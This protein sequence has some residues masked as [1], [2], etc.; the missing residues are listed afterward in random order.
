MDDDEFDR[1]DEAVEAGRETVRGDRWSK[2]LSRSDLGANVFACRL[3]WLGDFLNHQGFA[4]QAQWTVMGPFHESLAFADG[5][6]FLRHRGNSIGGFGVL[7]GQW[8]VGFAA[9]RHVCALLGLV[10]PRLLKGERAIPDPELLAREVLR[11]KTEDR[12]A[13]EARAE[14]LL[15]PETAV[16]HIPEAVFR[17][18]W[19]GPK[20]R[21]GLGERDTALMLDLTSVEFLRRVVREPLDETV[22]PREDRPVQRPVKEQ[23]SRPVFEPRIVVRELSAEDEP[24]AEDDTGFGGPACLSSVTWRKDGAEVLPGTW[25]ATPLYGWSAWGIWSRGVS[26]ENLPPLEWRYHVSLRWLLARP[27]LVWSHDY[28]DQWTSPQHTARCWFPGNGRYIPEGQ[29]AAPHLHGTGHP[30]CG[31]TAV[32][33]PPTWISQGHSETKNGGLMG[34]VE[35]SGR[36][37]DA[38]ARWWAEKVR[39]VAAFRPTRGFHPTMGHLEPLV[40]HPYLGDEVAAVFDDPRLITARTCSYDEW[41]AICERIIQEGRQS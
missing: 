15:T 31:I 33:G 19:G 29:A 26:F 27:D 40:G 4:H 3:E 36:I 14:L 5:G 11:Q 41:L 18:L 34:L 28:W 1:R 25:S 24:L 37:I 30:V 12:K 38:N 21:F 13:M 2:H 23:P 16:Q 22:R 20:P 17:Q 39:C 9:F 6:W 7:T 32:D 10:P 35:L 8:I